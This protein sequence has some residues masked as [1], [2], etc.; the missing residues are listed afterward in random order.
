MSRSRK[1]YR[2]LPF[3]DLGIILVFLEFKNKIGKEK[4][5]WDIAKNILLLRFGVM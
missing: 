5:V 3:D 4:T 2:F 1:K